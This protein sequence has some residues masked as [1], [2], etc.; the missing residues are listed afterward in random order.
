MD[1]KFILEAILFS[2]QKPLSTKELKDVFAGAPEHAERVHEA[3]PA[4]RPV[5][6]RPENRRDHRERRHP[7][8][9]VHDR[10]AIPG[11]GQAGLDRGHAS[12]G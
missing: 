8:Q 7:P 11:Q 12:D 1:L 5:D 9:P 3:A 6:Q 10:R 4:P 2:A